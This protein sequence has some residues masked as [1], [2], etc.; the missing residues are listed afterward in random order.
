[1]QPVS[2]KSNTQET[3]AGHSTNVENISE[4][5]KTETPKTET[6]KTETPN[7]ETPKTASTL[8][9]NQQAP[10][11]LLNLE[12]TENKAEN[13][14]TAPTQSGIQNDQQ[15]GSSSENTNIF[16][17]SCST[18]TNNQPE[19]NGSILKPSRLGFVKLDG[20][21]PDQRKRS[22]SLVARQTISSLFPPKRAYKK[23]LPEKTGLQTSKTTDEEFSDDE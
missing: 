4:T 15:P 10:A 1:M 7:T 21:P 5:P 8:G 2:S 22:A 9:Q 3:T 11:S 17:P 14:N 20:G 19:Q 12:D 6:P 13:S 18:H 23:T 16:Q